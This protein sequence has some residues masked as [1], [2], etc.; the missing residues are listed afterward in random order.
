MKNVKL[1]TLT[2]IWYTGQNKKALPGKLLKLQ[3]SVAKWQAVQKPCSAACFLPE[4][5]TGHLSSDT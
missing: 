3:R 1:P 2:Q 5:V 4:S